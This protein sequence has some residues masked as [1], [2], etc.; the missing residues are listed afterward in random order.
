MV[1]LRKNQEKT[2]AEK[3][4]EINRVKQLEAGNRRLT[5]NIANQINNKWQ[6]KQSN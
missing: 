4:K 5:N 6:S 2:V 1:N 3:A